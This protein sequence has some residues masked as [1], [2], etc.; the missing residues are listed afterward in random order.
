ME[1]NVSLEIISSLGLDRTRQVCHK[2]SM[3]Y[4]I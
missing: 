1:N 2:S 3:Y 4:A